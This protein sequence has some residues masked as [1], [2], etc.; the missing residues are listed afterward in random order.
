MKIAYQGVAGAVSHI[1]AKTVYPD[2]FYVPCDTFE[3][4]MDKVQNGGT[5]STEE[6]L[7]LATKYNEYVM[8]SLRTMWGLRLDT[9]SSRFG[10]R[11][12]DFFMKNAQRHIDDGCLCIDNG[13]V[14]LT[15]KGIFVSDGVMSDL[16]FVE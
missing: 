3:Q 16:M 8:L 11:F 12:L 14:R 1:A 10:K 9:I 7:D 15:T 2:A 4:A 6:K 13:N 5:Y